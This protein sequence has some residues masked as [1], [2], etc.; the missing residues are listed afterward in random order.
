MRI[1]GIDDGDHT[2]VV[3]SSVKRWWINATTV[4]LLAGYIPDTER[5]NANTDVSTDVGTLDV[6]D[7]DLTTAIAD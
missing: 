4:S 1:W 6:G 5:S 3:T 7:N 2:G